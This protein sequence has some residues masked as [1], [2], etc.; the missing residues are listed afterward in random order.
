MRRDLAPSAPLATSRSSILAVDDAAADRLLAAVLIATLIR[1]PALVGRFESDLEALVLPDAGHGALVSCLLRLG[2]CDD[3][4]RRVA[5]ELPGALEE[6]MSD[7]HVQIAPPVT[8]TDGD[9]ALMCAAEA[10]AKLTARAGAAREIEEAMHDMTGLV[11]EGLTWRLGQAAAAQQSAGRS[12]GDDDAGEDRA[13]LSAR[14]QA[15]IDGE[16]WVRRRH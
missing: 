1:H 10:L 9:L 14:L 8:T 6:L 3:L 4:A 16:V 12:L 5:A 13:A 15:L 11:D 2:P 7:R